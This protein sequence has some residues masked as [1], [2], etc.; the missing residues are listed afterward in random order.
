MRQRTDRDRRAA[1]GAQLLGYGVNPAFRA[2]LESA[3]L[4]V[5]GERDD[6]ASRMVELAAHPF[7]VATLFLPQ[8]RSSSAAPHPLLAGF[9][10]AIAAA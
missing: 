6:G 9:A 7:F 3:G 2:S 1:G 5:S 4:T 10:R 8:V